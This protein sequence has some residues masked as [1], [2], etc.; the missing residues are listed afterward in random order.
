MGPIEENEDSHLDEH[1]WA[2][3][4]NEKA[5]LVR[6]SNYTQ[7]TFHLPFLIGIHKKPD[8]DMEQG[9]GTAMDDEQKIVAKD[10]DNTGKG[11]DGRL[12]T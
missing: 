12:E 6:A 7:M 5:D 8:A 1:M 3:D 11:G 9:Q 10:E 2:P 4:E